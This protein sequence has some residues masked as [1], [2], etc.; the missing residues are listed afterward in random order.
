LTNTRSRPRVAAHRTPI[1]RSSPL[2]FAV[3]LVYQ[4]ERLVAFARQRTQVALRIVPR[5]GFPDARPVVRRE[6]RRRQEVR[7]SSGIACQI[8]SGKPRLTSPPVEPYL[9]CSSGVS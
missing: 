8:H 9:K 5:F 7:D 6:T 3:L 1:G 2:P 4:A